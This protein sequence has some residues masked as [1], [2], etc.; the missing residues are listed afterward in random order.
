M[1]VRILGPGEFKDSDGKVIKEESCE[2]MFFHMRSNLSEV[3]ILLVYNQ[4]YGF[5]FD[6]ENFTFCQLGDW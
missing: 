2:E 4:Y 3:K 5:S 6:G 1:K